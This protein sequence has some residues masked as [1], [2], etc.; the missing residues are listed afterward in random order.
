VKPVDLA[1][2]GVG[3]FNLSLAA[4]AEPVPGLEVA[5]FDR[6]D[7]FRWHPGLLLDGTTLQV[8]FLADLVTL[9]NPTSPMSF[10]NYLRVRGRLFPFY[11]A[12]RFHI[13]R[14]EYDDYGRWAS[15]K[16]PSCR[17]SSPVTEVRWVAAEEAFE[18]VIEG[19]DAVLARNVA[20]GVGTSPAVPEALR[21]LVGDPDVLAVHSADYLPLPEV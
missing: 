7:E 16:L 8:P 18:L 6:R 10:L 2:V 21:D 1:G 5:V 14:A 15:A 4:L 11:F 17:F 3:P 13:P 9:V 12:E 19:A 20:L